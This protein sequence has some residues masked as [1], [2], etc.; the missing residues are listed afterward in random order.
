MYVSALSSPLALDGRAA[1]ARSFVGVKKKLLIIG[2]VVVV[3]LVVGGWFVYDNL[4]STKAD[5]AFTLDTVK[6]SGATTVVSAT[7]LA[8]F[9]GV[10]GASD[11]SEA[12]Y[13]MAEDTAAGDKTITAR[14]NDVTGTAELTAEDLSSTNVTVG[15]AGLTSDQSLRD[16]AVR[17]IYLKT[18][19]FPTAVFE[20]TTPVPIAS[21]PAAGTP[22]NVSVPGNLTLKGATKPVT[23]QVQAISVDGVINVVGTI[24][25]KLTDFGID[26]PNIPGLATVK[27]EATIEF[28]LE[29][30]RQ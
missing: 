24:A 29:L 15:L 22:L 10:W 2:P 25:L 21:V 18:D 1:V 23:A 12:G 14:T 13:R 7:G 6:P 5:T 4:S 11:V 9:V 8:D 27:D 19:E 16:T 26:P 3:A 28:K 30:T 17:G 20:Q